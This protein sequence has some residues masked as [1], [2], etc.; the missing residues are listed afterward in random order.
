MNIIWER[1]K[2]HMVLKTMKDTLEQVSQWNSDNLRTYGNWLA[3]CI[4]RGRDLDIQM[5]ERLASMIRNYI[6]VY[7]IYVY[8]DVHP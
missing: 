6:E 1:I 2:F 8:S 5:T 3:N 4:R 7:D